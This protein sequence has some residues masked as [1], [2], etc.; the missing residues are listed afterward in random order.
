MGGMSNRLPMT[1][2]AVLEVDAAKIK[3]EVG[4][5]DDLARALRGH[6]ARIKASEL[7]MAFVDDAFFHRR[8]REWA[9]EGFDRI[10]QPLL[11]PEAR[12]GEGR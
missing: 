6:R 8:R 11:Q 12:Y 4:A 10:S 9:P 1:S 2:A 7:R 3:H 5:L